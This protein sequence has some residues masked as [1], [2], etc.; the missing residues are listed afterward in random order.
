MRLNSPKYPLIWSG[1]LK[2]NQRK[3]PLTIKNRL[4]VKSINVSALVCIRAS[5]EAIWLPCQRKGQENC[6]FI[7]ANE[8]S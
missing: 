4:Y 8:H 3:K 2:I 7:T 1:K 5:K 6:S